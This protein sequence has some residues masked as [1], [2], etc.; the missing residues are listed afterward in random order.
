MTAGN[1]S[2]PSPC[3]NVCVMDPDGAYCLGCFRTIEEI[4]RWIELDAAGRLAVWDRITERR[5][6]ADAADPDS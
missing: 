4:T 6:A 5:K 2:V 3:I 1:D